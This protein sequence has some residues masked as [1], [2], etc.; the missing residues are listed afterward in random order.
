MYEF[1]DRINKIKGAVRRIKVFYIFLDAILVLLIFS[2][3][4]LLINIPVV[5]AVI[6]FT[7]YA[8]LAII[9]RKTNIFRIIEENYEYFRERLRT[10]YD[11]K[12][13]SSIIIKHLNEEITKKMDNAVEYSSFLDARKIR[14]KVFLSIFLVFIFLFF[15]FMNIKVVDAPNLLSSIVTKKPVEVPSSIEEEGKNKPTASAQRKKSPGG[16][17]EAFEDIY[18]QS[19]IAKIEG[20]K[21]NL[22]LYVGAGELKVRDLKDF[23]ERKESFSTISPSFPA[24][25]TIAESYS[26]NIPEKYEE[27]VRKYFEKLTEESK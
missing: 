6:I 7:I 17:K 5:Y 13:R 3:V 23:K 24:T 22:E 16:G 11:N 15:S 18:G 19:S 9:K 25:P 8:I 14:L 10:A 20:E 26:E 1:I 2:L 4:F 21:I 12:E 27:V